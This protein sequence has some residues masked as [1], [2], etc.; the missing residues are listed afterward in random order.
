MAE[1]KGYVGALVAPAKKNGESIS[2]RQLPASARLPLLRVYISPQIPIYGVAGGHSVMSAFIANADQSIIAHPVLARRFNKSLNS[3]MVTG[4]QNGFLLMV[5]TS[6]DYTGLQTVFLMSDLEKIRAASPDRSFY[7]VIR[8][9]EDVNQ[10]YKI[11]PSYFEQLG[12]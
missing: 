8:G 4:V 5:P 12:D 3:S 7:L 6:V 10:T 2:F 11:G 1:P 9:T